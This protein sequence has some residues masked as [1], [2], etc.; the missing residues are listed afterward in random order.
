MK[1]QQQQIRMWTP[2]SQHP[3]QFSLSSAPR[4][5]IFCA[6][7]LALVFGLFLL[8]TLVL[9]GQSLSI[10]HNLVISVLHLFSKVPYCEPYPLGGC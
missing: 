1:S 2:I 8:S 9:H 6:I 3:S 7:I 5:S 4:W 10:L